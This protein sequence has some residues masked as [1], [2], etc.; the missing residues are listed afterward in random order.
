MS[1]ARS[2]NEI[3]P[4]NPSTPTRPE[5]Q[6]SEV[7]NDVKHETSGT[8]PISN[9]VAETIENYSVA[10]LIAQIERQKKIISDDSQKIQLLEAKCVKFSEHQ[11]ELETKLDIANKERESAL[12]NKENTVIRFAVSEQKL[13]KEQQLRNLLDCKYR[14]VQKECE[15]LRNKLQS[16]VNDKN[17]ICLLLDNKFYECKHIQQQLDSTK[18]ELQEF[19]AKCKEDSQE[20]I[21]CENGEEKVDESVREESKLLEKQL[22]EQQANV[23][24]LRHEKHNQEQVTDKLRA[25][26]E[27]WQK[28]CEELIQ[29][30]T[31]L[32]SKVQHLEEQC[33]KESII[34]K[35]V[36]QLELKIQELVTDMEYCQSRESELLGFTQQLT[37]KNVQLLSEFS[38]FETKIHQLTC[39][40][41]T[42]KRQLKEQE[43]KTVQLS[44][45]LEKERMLFSVDNSELSDKLKQTRNQLDEALQQIEDL[46][47]ET[48]VAGRKNDLRLRE[49]TKE[50]E[51]C[52]KKIEQYEL[53]TFN[54]NLSS[55]KSSSNNQSSSNSEE[56]LYDKTIDSQTL[57]E[58]IVKLQRISAKKSEKIDFLEDHV[59]T[60]TMEIQKRQGFIKDVF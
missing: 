21:K 3:V 53:N 9:E 48:V 56:A 40:S 55:S 49:M 6:V 2:L 26:L 41:T 1:S 19:K 28:K 50:L 39:E 35:T 47:E 5:S 30:K 4:E 42:L 29:E 51:Q 23:I 24:L 32:L 15:H 18:Q 17:R 44:H 43:T 33:Q 14:E 31:N 45:Q 16:M 54:S 11:K 12:K 13:L 37:D 25:E 38:A 7:E 36:P 52:R 34:S 46:K 59:K 8:A 58:H 57:I 10:D 20:R 22:R 60:L 27:H